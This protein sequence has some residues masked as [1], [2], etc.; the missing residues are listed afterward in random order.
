MHSGQVGIIG[1]LE[2]LIGQQRVKTRRATCAQRLD[3]NRRVVTLLGGHYRR[4]HFKPV[5]FLACHL[6]NPAIQSKREF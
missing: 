4:D 6:S 1:S 3:G 5:V 2:L